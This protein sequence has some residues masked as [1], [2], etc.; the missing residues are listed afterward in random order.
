MPILIRVNS[1]LR[2][3]QTNIDALVEYSTDTLILLTPEL[4]TEAVQ[5]T[6]V[7][8]A[9]TRF[10][11]RGMYRDSSFDEEGYFA[12]KATIYPVM[13]TGL[14]GQQT[15]S[16]AAFSFRIGELFS[17]FIRIPVHKSLFP[18]QTELPPTIAADLAAEININKQ[19]IIDLDVS[20]ADVSYVDGGINAI[21]IALN[22]KV[23]KVIGKGLSTND[24]VQV[25]HYTK[26]ETNNTFETVANVN[27]ERSRITAVETN[28]AEKTYVDSELNLKQD[29]LFTDL[30]SK[31]LLN[32]NDI[33]VI[34]DSEDLNNSKR[35]TVQSIIS[36]ASVEAADFGFELV[37][38]LPTTNISANRIYLLFVDGPHGNVYEE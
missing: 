32:L 23:D 16:N 8:P 18:E 33:L 10:E 4:Q 13:T 2:L 31:T 36:L 15:T 7:S 12:Y 20:K 6:W 14:I 35:T 27:I 24:F 5:F 11:E 22:T 19:D 29:K 3:A 26:T 21:N 1:A 38:E 34:N 37:N 9:N 25:N 30:V 28:K 17:P